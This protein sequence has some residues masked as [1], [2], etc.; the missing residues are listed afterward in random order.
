MLWKH[1]HALHFHALHRDSLMTRLHHFN[2]LPVWVL[3]ADRFWCIFGP[4]A[5]GTFNQNAGP[6]T[7]DR[8]GADPILCAGEEGTLKLIVF[9]PQGPVSAFP[10]NDP[11]LWL[12][13]GCKSVST[14]RLYQ[15]KVPL[16]YRWR[17]VRRE[18]G[19]GEDACFYFWVCV[20]VCN[21]FDCYAL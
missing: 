14:W 6:G 2:S 11:Q 18:D 19:F 15:N 21:I 12:L 3:L 9:S 16:H 8:S 10:G 7:N 17:E 20:C 5:R 1:L 13:T 4:L